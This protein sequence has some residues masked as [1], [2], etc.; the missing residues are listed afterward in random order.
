V[1][2]VAAHAN[3][4]QPQPPQALAIADRVDLTLD[5]AFVRA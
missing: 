1:R 3:G 2:S 4:G 5:L